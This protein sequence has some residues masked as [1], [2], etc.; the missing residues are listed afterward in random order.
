MIKMFLYRIRKLSDKETMALNGVSEKYMK[1]SDTHNYYWTFMD[2]NLDE[3]HWKNVMPYMNVI[4][5]E[6]EIINLE[7]LKHMIGVP[8]EATALV[9][10]HGNP[11]AFLFNWHGGSKYKRLSDREVETY[12]ISQ[13]ETG[14]IFEMEQ[15][16]CI[17]DYFLS[18]DLEKVS[19]ESLD[20][21]VYYKCND[22]MIKV[23]K[24]S[25]QVELPEIGEDEAFFYCHYY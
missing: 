20:Y 18:R 23:L 16:A 17:S 15:I 6:R 9:N 12:T 25:G 14:Y 1:E 13:V 4:G 11:R 8:Q 24:E 22:E 21:Y 3:Y 5:I 7:M 19:K 2:K 10:A